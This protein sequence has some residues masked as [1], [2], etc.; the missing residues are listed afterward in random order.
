VI[1]SSTAVVE[2]WKWDGSLDSLPDSFTLVPMAPLELPVSGYLLKPVKFLNFSSSDIRV[3]FC[4]D[5][6]K[7][8]VPIFPIK[9]LTRLIQNKY[10][11]A[12]LVT[13]SLSVSFT[14]RLHIATEITCPIAWPTTKEIDRNICMSKPVI[15][16][17]LAVFLVESH[18]KPI[19]TK[20]IPTAIARRS[21][22]S[23]TGQIWYVRRE[24]TVVS[25]K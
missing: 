17:T 21:G 11:S 24:R 2:I 5:F 18:F 25:V 1:F 12:C 22:R 9:T 15:C 7:E 4:R 8:I 16:C 14:H 10:E 3:Y 6:D 20:I 23:S 19:W 13:F